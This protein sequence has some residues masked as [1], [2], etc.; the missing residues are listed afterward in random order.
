[1]GKKSKRGSG[2]RPGSNRAERVAAR[3]ARQAAALAPPPRPFAGLASECDFVALRTFV[4][5]AT[6][7]LELKEPEGSRND[8]SI[9]T[10]LPGAVPALARETGGT[11]EAF[12][13]LQTEPDRSAL[14]VELAA[15]I[16]WAAHAEPGSEFDLESA[17]EAPTLDEVLVT[18]ATL[19]ITVHQD[20]SWWF[21]EGTDVPAEIAAMFERANDSV[22]PTARLVV[23]SNSGAPWWVDAGERAHLRW[24]RPEPEDDLMSAM[25]RLHAA[26]RLTM[27]EG[28]RFAGSFRTHGLLVPVF[29]LDNEMH[30]EEWQAGLNQLDQWLGDALAD[31]SPLTIDQRSSRDGIRGRQV[32]L[33]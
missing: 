5:S 16:A 8:V 1:M 10:I 29:D 15:A 33:R 13:G 18:D 22:L 17:E 14:T 30:H 23:D 19:D 11:T 3:K 26:G 28:S 32:T 21:A 20:F 4:A 24:I 7:R 6:A 31:T 2:P 12:V 25:A 27:G 9:V